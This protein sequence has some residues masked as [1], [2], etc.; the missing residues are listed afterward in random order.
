MG[1]SLRWHEFSMMM[2]APA[3]A[4]PRDIFKVGVNQLISYLNGLAGVA[5]L[6]R[7]KIRADENG[8]PTLLR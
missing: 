8:E 7:R 1:L 3:D 4:T 5:R 6:E 2:K